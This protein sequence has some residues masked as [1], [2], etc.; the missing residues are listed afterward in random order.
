MKKLVLLLVLGALFYIGIRWAQNVHEEASFCTLDGKICPNGAV[1]GRIP[2]TCEF[3]PCD[4][5]KWKTKREGM[6]EFQ[7]PDSLETTYIGAHEWPPQI[8][9]EAQQKA[10]TGST[11]KMNGKTYCINSE[12]GAA[13]GST[14]ITYTYETARGGNT[15][16]AVF[17]LRYP[18][19]GNYA[20][21]PEQKKCEDEQNSFN[22]DALIDGIIR[23]VR[24]F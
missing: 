13:A 23:T 10:C 20:E 16:R 7:Y 17:T 24:V 4:T 3:A 1:V 22:L 5:Q 15:V 19:C 14:Y 12:V 18:Q 9:I 21:G 11:R 8:T 2:P 6:V